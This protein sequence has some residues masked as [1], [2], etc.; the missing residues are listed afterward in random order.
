MAGGG[1]DALYGL[2]RE[3]AMGPGKPL[4][5]ALLSLMRR[6][7][8]DP[9]VVAECIRPLWP[10]L[11][12]TGARLR[13]D[14]RNTVLAAWPNYYH[15]GE[16]HDLPFDLALLLYEARAYA[17]AR[18]LFEAS[19][20]LYGEDAATRWNLGLCHV[21][22]GDPRAARASFRR[23]SQLDQGSSPGSPSR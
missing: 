5:S 17:D 1:P 4:P 18:A 3:L 22:L 21:A 20:R 16:P 10:H 8:P 14:I 6:C 2:R 13:R 9:R 11:A 19:L 15:V 23:V 7:G 12:A